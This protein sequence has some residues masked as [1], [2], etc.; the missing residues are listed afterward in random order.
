VTDI[1]DAFRAGNDLR[2]D[3]DGTSRVQIETAFEV[4]VGVVEHDKGALVDGLQGLV[5]LR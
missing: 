2:A 4:L 1:D 5:E 3:G